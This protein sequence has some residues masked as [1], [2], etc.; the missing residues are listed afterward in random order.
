MTTDEITSMAQQ[1]DAM[2]T[3]RVLPDNAKVS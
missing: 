3:I 2:L 1:A